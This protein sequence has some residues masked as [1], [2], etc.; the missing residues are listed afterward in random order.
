[1]VDHGSSRYKSS[2]RTRDDLLDELRRYHARVREL[3][4]IVAGINLQE[5]EARNQISQLERA[6]QSAMIRVWYWSAETRRTR[7]LPL[8][9]DAG[10]SQSDSADRDSVSEENLLDRIHPADQKTLVSTWDRAFFEHIPYEIEYR[11]IHTGGEV[12]H[13]HEIGTPEFNESGRYLGHFGT[14]QEVT[15]R[16]RA[17]RA[18]KE[19][20]DELEVRVKER[21]VELRT[22]ETQFKQAARIARLGYWRFNEV[23]GKYLCISEE[24]ARIFGYTAEEFLA[25]FQL[26]T[27]DMELVYLAD[28][29]RVMDEYKTGKAANID[30]RIVHAD[31]S[32][33]HVREIYEDFVRDETGN[34]VEVMGTLQDI[35]ELKEAE[36]ALEQRTLDLEEKN[37]R[38]KREIAERNRIQ[39]ELKRYQEH[40]EDLVAERTAELVH[41][42]ERAEAASRAK[43]DFLA[44]MSHELRTPMHAI[45]GF[46]N[47]GDEKFSQPG[48]G[49]NYYGRIHSSGQRLLALL[50]ELLDLTK[51]EAGK[52]D[53]DCSQQHL[54][55][56]VELAIAEFATLAAD[57]NLTVRV[58]N[59]AQTPVIAIDSG[60]ILQV[61]RNLLSNAIK[62]SYENGSVKIDIGVEDANGGTEVVVSVEDEGI[63]IPDDE[64]HSVFEKFS[65]SS[66]TNTGAGGTGLG[67]AICREIIELHGG[68]IAAGCGCAGAQL[69]FR[70]PV[71]LQSSQAA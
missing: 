56:I 64:L 71:M 7:Y 44:N 62:F 26:L 19:A 23:T 13:N 10:D 67:L 38:L 27:Q 61:M 41:A 32:I 24:Y 20:R 9:R 39:K 1:M 4:P 60:R 52:M 14:T 12:Q 69:T 47:L 37:A 28:R 48:A 50:N 46:A 18:L 59:D 66:A 22:R 3:E 55:P 45:L 36:A 17:E 30:Y 40:L 16:V 54:L 11:L 15:D 21:T 65:Q 68:T 35:T 33:R 6:F 43:S 25:R 58:E 42:K 53:L 57:K 5:T 63:G 34:P 51:L 70:L 2:G 31:G 29:A 49:K 8:V